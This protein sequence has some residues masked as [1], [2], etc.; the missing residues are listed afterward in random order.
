MLQSIGALKSA[1][2]VLSKH[3]SS[4]AQVRVFCSEI[5]AREQD[6]F[7]G[8]VSAHLERPVSAIGDKTQYMSIFVCY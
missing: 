3:H 4:L 5:R 7:F 8:F 2:V 1:I 6:Q